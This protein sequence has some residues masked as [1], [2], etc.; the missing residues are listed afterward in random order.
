MQNWFKPK[1]PVPPSVPINTNLQD[2]GVYKRVRNFGYTITKVR[3]I[4]ALL[5]LWMFVGIVLS[6]FNA[7]NERSVIF[8]HLHAVPGADPL[9]LP[10]AQYWSMDW[11][12][13]PMH[14]LSS[15]GATWG[16]TGVARNSCY[17]DS[18]DC[19]PV[20]WQTDTGCLQPAL[21]PVVVRDEQGY[22]YKSTR[23]KFRQ[24][25][26]MFTCL[27]EKIGQVNLFINNQHSYS[28]GSTHN[29]HL[30]VAGVLVVFSII[31]L[32]NL[33]GTVGDSNLKE[34]DVKSRRI[35]LALALL[36]YVVFVYSWTNSN[37]MQFDQNKHRPVG[38]AS[39]SYSTFY[40]LMALLI[41]NQEGLWKDHSSDYRRMQRNKTTKKNREEQDEKD[42][43]RNVATAAITS[44]DGTQVPKLQDGGFNIP[45][46]NEDGAPV[47]ALHAI[48]TAKAPMRHEMSIRGFVTEPWQT[49]G[50]IMTY[51]RSLE[52]NKDSIDDVTLEVCEYITT[53]VHS[54]Y[55]YGQFLT[56]PLVL[57]VLS[58][59]RHNYSMDTHT[60]IVFVAAWCIVLVDLFLYRMWWAF[61]IHK[62]VTFYRE[63][64]IGEFRAMELVTTVSVI[65]QVS[66]YIFMF[67]SKYFSQLYIILLS[68]YLIFTVVV[69]V[70]AMYGMRM[71]RRTHGE[72]KAEF[73]TR[74]TQTQRFDDLVGYFQKVDY[75][76]FVLHAFGCLLTLWACIILEADRTFEP[77]YM[78][79][80]LISANWGPGWQ[81]YI[82]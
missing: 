19:D 25:Q 35:A 24:L 31:I 3:T 44:Q 63:K 66:V 1:H 68:I 52:V 37:A 43:D 50:R 40:M 42:L 32:S 69:K 38:I 34:P 46:R 13:S 59:H 2:K 39:M 54:K 6:L 82:Q 74:R 79:S 73:I 36:V 9:A 76:L 48:V 78:S 30:L 55:V 11:M 12:M 70:V 16:S 64:D 53:P 26:P 77:P 75:F 45:M 65:F 33:L 28:I 10:P 58:M 51:T 60:Q 17:D 41:F 72:T 7:I 23:T 80:E 20:W 71:N 21:V 22:F 67:M 14:L 62:G 61:Q 57:I 49:D 5:L 18:G 4:N 8:N 56:M 81:I 15:A 29:I 27:A 47:Q